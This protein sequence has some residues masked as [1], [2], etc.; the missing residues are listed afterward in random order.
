MAI[1]FFMA[2]QSVG[3]S[4]PFTLNDVELMFY[5][6][7]PQVIKRL[8]TKPLIILCC[9]PLAIRFVNF[10]RLMSYNKAKPV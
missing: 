7:G 4:P 6:F 1:H 2:V 3:L 8:I 5:M 9:C 10:V